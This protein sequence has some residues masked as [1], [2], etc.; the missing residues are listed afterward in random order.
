MREVAL[1]GP[2]VLVLRTQIADRGAM[3]P[4]GVDEARHVRSGG[5]DGRVGAL[6][7]P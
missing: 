6:A 5:P 4:H 7:S 1:P 3:G 2:L